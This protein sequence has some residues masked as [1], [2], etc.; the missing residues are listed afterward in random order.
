MCRFLDKTTQ[1]DHAD[2]ATPTT[3]IFCTGEGRGTTLL[4]DVFYTD[5]RTTLEGNRGQYEKKERP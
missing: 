3:H 5:G 2:N 1:L 4:L